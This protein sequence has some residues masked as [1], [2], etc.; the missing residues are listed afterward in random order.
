[1][2]MSKLEK[3]FYSKV[4]FAAVVVVPVRVRVQELNG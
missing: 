2:K 1:M 4:I 3:C